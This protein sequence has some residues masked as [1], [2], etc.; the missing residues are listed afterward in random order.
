M[1]H[2]KAEINHAISQR[3]QFFHV[4]KKMAEIVDSEATPVDTFVPEARLHGN[5][6]RKLIAFYKEKQ[7]IVE[8]SSERTKRNHFK[9]PRGALWFQLHI[10]RVS[11]SMEKSEG[12][13]AERGQENWKRYSIV[14]VDLTRRPPYCWRKCWRCYWSRAQCCVKHLPCN[15]LLPQQCCV[16]SCLV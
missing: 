4:N 11:R 6:R 9:R 7:K 5:D 15:M 2:A 1:H 10:R 3:R 14:L 16:K 12:M 13:Y 8:E